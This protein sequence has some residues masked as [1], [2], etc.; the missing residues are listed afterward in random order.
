MG[1]TSQ[2]IPYFTEFVSQDVGLFRNTELRKNFADR[3]ESESSNP[4]YP[5]VKTESDRQTVN[6]FER[7]VYKDLVRTK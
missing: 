4:P 2:E 1:N 5:N 6:C 7:T 3:E